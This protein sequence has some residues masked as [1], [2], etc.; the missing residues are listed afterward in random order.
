MDSKKRSN[1]NQSKHWSRYSK[2]FNDE[3]NDEDDDIDNDSEDD[4]IPSTLQ[5]SPDE[6]DAKFGRQW[7]SK[8]P[9]KRKI[10]SANI[11]RQQNGVGR[12]VAGIQ[13][14]KEAFQVLIRQAM[15]LILV[16]G[17]NR[18]VHLILE[19]WNKKNSDKE[20]QWRDT[21]LE[22]M[23]AFIGLLLLAG[24]HRSKNESFNG[25]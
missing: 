18:R 5:E 24:V 8:E 22:E 23:W 9:S 19:Q 1:S 6:S 16:K 12:P 25:L 15:V 10:S 3:S 2:H 20:Y 4:E 13:T 21:D 14:V 7:T 11:L 17:T